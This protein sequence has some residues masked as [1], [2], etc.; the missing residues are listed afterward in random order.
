MLKILEPNRRYVCRVYASHLKT[1]IDCDDILI[2]TQRKVERKAD[3]KKEKKMAAKLRAEIN[4]N[5]ASLKQFEKV[6][7]KGYN[8]AL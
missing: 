4:E 5:Q 6:S 2:S 7:L 1:Q 3:L 8:T